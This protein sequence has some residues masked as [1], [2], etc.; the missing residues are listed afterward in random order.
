MR[1]LLAQR[2]PFFTVN[3]FHRLSNILDNAGQVVLGITVVT[4]FFANTI[5]YRSVLFGGLLIF[6]SWLT[7]LWLAKRGDQ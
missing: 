2:E 3:Q 6:V 7:S 5:S 1:N 4:P